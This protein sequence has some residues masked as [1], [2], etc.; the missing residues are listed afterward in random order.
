MLSKEQKW[1][2]GLLQA[3]KIPGHEN[4]LNIAKCASY[5]SLAIKPLS[6]TVVMMWALYAILGDWRAAFGGTVTVWVL[7]LFSRGYVWVARWDLRWF[8]LSV[9]LSM[10]IYLM[11]DMQPAW[12]GGAAGLPFWAKLTWAFGF[13]IIAAVGYVFCVCFVAV[14]EAVGYPVRDMFGFAVQL[15]AE[16]RMRAKAPNW[17]LPLSKKPILVFNEK[18]LAAIKVAQL[19]AESESGVFE[20]A[21][22][23]QGLRWQQYCAQPHAF[24]PM[25]WQKLVGWSNKR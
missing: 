18:G 14:V 5:A 8:C 10:L 9:A 24:V 2:L 25:G 15:W 12:W 7:Y 22:S 20:G 11:C 4:A 1:M 3:M 19:E 21:V 17:F 6:S 13:A 16:R 23:G